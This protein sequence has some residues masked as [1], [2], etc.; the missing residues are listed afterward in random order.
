MLPRGSTPI[1]MGS[2]FRLSI[3][4][5]SPCFFYP[6]GLNLTIPLWS[7]FL[8]SCQKK[9]AFV[10]QIISTQV[11]DFYYYFLLPGFCFLFAL[12]KSWTEATVKHY[13]YP[14]N[15]KMFH[16]FHRP[17]VKLLLSFL[18][19]IA[20]SLGPNV[21]SFLQHMP[22]SAAPC[23]KGWCTC[24]G[25]NSFI[26]VVFIFPLQPTDLC[27]YIWKFW[28]RLWGDF[29]HWWRSQRVL[30]RLLEVRE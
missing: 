7:C 20:H 15:C 2:V 13:W 11:W 30:S 29:F 14:S 19:Y 12:F 21:V 10:S 6:G 3:T 16:S 24:C 9:R 23:L 26:L 22:A 18:R 28:Q 4:P 1:Q 8:W 17:C 5:S 25:E 27:S